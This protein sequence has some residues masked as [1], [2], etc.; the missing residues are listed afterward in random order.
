MAVKFA[1]AYGC[2]VTAFTS[3]PGKFDEAKGFGANQVISSKDSAAIRKLGGSLDLL[4]STVNVTL[5]WEAMIDTLAPNGRLHVVGVV[6]PEP[7]PGGGILAHLAAAQ[8]LGFAH[9]LTGRDRNDAGLRFTAQRHAADR[10]L[11]DEQYQ[12]GVCPA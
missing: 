6:V 5:D 1:A 7:I 2:H 10:A 3:S 12:R 4:I 11:P 8:R 9:R